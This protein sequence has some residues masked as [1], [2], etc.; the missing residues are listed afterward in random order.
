MQISNISGCVKARA[1]HVTWLWYFMVGLTWMVD[2]KCGCFELINACHPLH[3]ANLFNRFRNKGY[4][5]SISFSDKN[6]STDNLCDITL[7]LSENNILIFI[8]QTRWKNICGIYWVYPWRKYWIKINSESI[9]TIPIHSD[10]CI[11]P[12]ANHSEPIRKT[13]CISFD[14]KRSKFNST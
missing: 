11:R 4:F 5:I 12:N 7:S 13:F 10:I 9:R 6:V 3:E 8:S 2:W 1:G 14:E